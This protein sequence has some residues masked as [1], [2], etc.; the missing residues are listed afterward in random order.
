M[1]T[2]LPSVNPRTA[3]RPLHREQ[4][5]ALQVGLHSENTGMNASP[6]V[7]D[8]APNTISNLLAVQ[9]RRSPR[10]CSSPILAQAKQQS[11]AVEFLPYTIVSRRQSY[12]LRFLDAY[13]V[14]RMPYARRD[15]GYLGLGAY[16][17]G[18]NDLGAKLAETAPVVM[19]FAPGVRCDHASC[20]VVSSAGTC[21]V[22]PTQL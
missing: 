4:V 8:F 1:H 7:R 17:D 10:R 20:L 14:V 2:S 15:E 11:P 21:D 19:R 9:L 18:E 13:T 12:D 16:F 6:T 3:L 5:C 22:P